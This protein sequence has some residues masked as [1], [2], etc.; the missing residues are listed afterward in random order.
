MAMNTRYWIISLLT[1]GLINQLLLNYL[2][3]LTVP[4]LI[5]TEAPIIIP[6]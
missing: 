6:P 1:L 4:L 5:W 2:N 3:D